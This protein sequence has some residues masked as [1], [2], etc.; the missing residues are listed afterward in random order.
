[1]IHIVFITDENYIMPTKAAIR[2]IIRNASGNTQG[3]IYVVG[4]IETDLQNHFAGLATDRFYI[5]VIPVIKENRLAYKKEHLY[6]SSAALYK[7]MLPELLGKL[8]KVL[9]LDGDVIVE[10]DLR[11]L[12]DTDIEGFYLAA[13]EDMCAVK[14]EN[15]LEKTGN[16]RYFN[17]GVMLLNLAMLRGEN[18]PKELID[19]RMRDEDMR[20]MDQNVFNRVLGGKVKYLSAKFNFMKVN[21]R[22]FTEREI[23]YFYGISS[24][25]Y[26]T[27]CN[28]PV[29]LHF[30]NKEKP[31]NTYEALDFE[32][33][34]MYLE[35]EEIPLVLK[36]CY[37]RFRD[38]IR[39][40]VAE[41]ETMYSLSIQRLER[42]MMFRIRQDNE[43]QAYLLK[44][45][46]KEIDSLKMLVKKY[47]PEEKS[48]LEAEDG[49]PEKRYVIYGAG[50]YA[51]QVFKNCHAAKK[52]KEIL[53]FAVTEPEKNPLY[54]YGIPVV[55]IGELKKQKDK[56]TV[57][58]AVSQA[59]LPEICDKLYAFGFTD[60]VENGLQ[61]KW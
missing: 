52:D 10:G 23:G 56:V 21:L 38:D 44:E 39:E 9:Y 4:D 53:A 37:G 33:W 61:Y 15:V 55:S 16:E 18:M 49:R 57:I 13:V 7:F 48:D 6:V 30:T 51:M 26:R 24:A 59:Y 11:E 34:C 42:S 35:G 22:N 19:E 29:I 32:K 43:S 8:D 20:F 47:L 5:N 17:S 45:K 46:Q 50:D 54:L 31:W 36:N 60:I 1:M 25:E 14:Q 2:S 41:L 58:V 3:T 27:V 28:N 40:K 12:F